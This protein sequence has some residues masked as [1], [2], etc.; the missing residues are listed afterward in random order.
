MPHLTPSQLQAIITALYMARDTYTEHAINLR[1]EGT[2]I[3]ADA[4]TA[5]A[6]E[7]QQIIKLLEDT[8]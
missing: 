5:Q 4:F 3:L 8:L 6:V 1:T 7:A 2:T